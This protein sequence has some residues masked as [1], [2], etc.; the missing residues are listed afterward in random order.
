MPSGSDTMSIMWYLVSFAGLVTFFLLLSFSEFCC[1]KAPA[2]SNSQITDRVEPL[3]PPPYELFAPPSYESLFRDITRER[4][5]SITVF[6]V[7]V[8]DKAEIPRE[9]PLEFGEVIR[10]NPMGDGEVVT[11]PPPP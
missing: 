7:P 3:A 2:L 9:S 1:K 8:H 4:K 10:R 5:R 6:L 11:P